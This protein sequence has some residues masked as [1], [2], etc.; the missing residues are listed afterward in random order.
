VSEEER[1]GKEVSKQRKEGTRGSK[2][3][4]KERE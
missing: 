3:K 2:W 1:E 4:G